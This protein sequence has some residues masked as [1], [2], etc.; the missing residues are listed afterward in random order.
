MIRIEHLTKE[1]ASGLRAVDDISLEVRAGEVFGFLGPNGA[2]KTTTI[3]ILTTLLRPSSGTAVVAGYDV[4]DQPV[5]VRMSFGYV[6]QQ[7]GVDPALTV[8][9]NLLLQGR[10]YH[11]PSSE[12]P[13]RIAFLLDLF[14]L[15]GVA[16]QSVGSLSGGMKRKLDI[17]TA[18]IHEPKLL[19]LDEPTLGLDPKSRADLWNYIRRLN[20]EQGVTI[21]LTTHYLDE[22][23]QLAH[24]VGILDQG[25][26][27][28]VGTPDQLKDSLGA[29]C[30]QLSFKAPLTE[31]ALAAFRRME[32][33]KEVLP[34]GE[35]VRFYLVNGRHF[36]SKVLQKVEEQGLTPE[37]VVLTRP[38]FDDVYL[39]YTGKSLVKENTKEAAPSSGGWGQWTQEEQEAWWGKKNKK[40]EAGKELDQKE[41]QAEKAEA[42]GGSGGGQ[43]GWQDWTQ[44]K[45]TQAE[46]EAWWNKRRAAEQK[47]KETPA[48]G[49]KAADQE[50]PAGDEGKEP[51]GDWK[52]PQWNKK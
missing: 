23:D 22:V 43:N 35:A 47:W 44:G 19:F 51:R 32:M 14:D 36:L 24:R 29:D 17:G 31:A 11:L 18:L 12:I 20:R 42:G 39:K 2:G 10:L 25:K 48:D 34:Q 26:I 28:T 50:K 41:P 37:T 38:T 8:R 6:G 9:E 30:I 5:A 40:G 7:S 13:K 1:Y 21:F 45:W 46:Q 33:I 15:N 16:D 27:Q 3:K 49:G 4:V 52:D